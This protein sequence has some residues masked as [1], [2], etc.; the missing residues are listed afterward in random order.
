VI[1][2]RQSSRQRRQIA[3][4]RLRNR[5]EFFERKIT[6]PTLNASHVTAVD[7]YTIREV[8]LG[9]SALLARALKPA[10]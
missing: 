6:F 2:H 7:V 9:P 4:E 3:A 5:A 1:R 8:L 10:S